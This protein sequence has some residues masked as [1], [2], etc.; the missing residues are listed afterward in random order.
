M[1][2]EILFQFGK[3][4]RD[5]RKSINLSQV[6]L[7]EKCGFH[8]NYIGMIERGERNPSLVNIYKISR[9][10]DMDLSEFLKIDNEI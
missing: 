7:A 8:R 4:V 9:A 2:E 10:F 3:R 5:L 6:D 1:K